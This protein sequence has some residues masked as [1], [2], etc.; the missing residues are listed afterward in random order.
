LVSLKL[1]VCH[2]LR[3]T[4]RAHP[5]N[6]LPCR[7]CKLQGCEG[8]CSMCMGISLSGIRLSCFSQPLPAYMC[9]SRSATS[10]A[11]P[12]TPGFLIAPSL[13]YFPLSNPQC[14]PKRTPTT[15]HLRFATSCH[16][17]SRIQTS[18]HRPL[19]K[20]SSQMRPLETARMREKPGTAPPSLPIRGRAHDS[21]DDVGSVHGN[22]SRGPR[23][24]NNH[25]SAADYRQ[26]APFQFFRFFVDWLELSTRHSSFD[27]NL[28]QSKRYF[29]TE[30]YSSHSQPRLLCWLLNLWSLDQHKHA[31]T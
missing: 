8:V 9:A 20:S 5:A 15:L 1:E 18:R 13:P 28:G 25:Y 11:F 12:L 7:S 21:F 16:P 23:Y 10:S 6:Q 26:G 2:L 14:K 22:L 29:W 3:R 4:P 27:I 17:L 24:D 30:T 19:H 31:H